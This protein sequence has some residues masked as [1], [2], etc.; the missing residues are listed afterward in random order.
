VRRPNASLAALLAASLLA[1]GCG[2]CGTPAPSLPAER[3][4]PGGATGLVLIPRLAAAAGQAAALHATLSAL[5]GQ[6]E[7]QALRGAL[8]AQLSF[9][10]FDPASMAGA[11]LDPARGAALAELPGAPGEQAGRLLLVLPVGDAGKL[12]ALLSRLARDRLGAVERGLENANGKP[13]E[14]WRRAAGEPAQLALAVLERTAL[15]GVGPSGPDAL[16]TA[17]ALDPALSL[18]RS[19]AWLRNRAALAEDAAVIL[20]LAPGS[21]PLSS[22]LPGEG[23]AAGLSATARSLRLVV[24]APLGAL[25]ARLRPLAGTGAGRTGATPLDPATLVALRVSASPAALRGLVEGELS[26]GTLPAPLLQVVSALEPPI[27]AGLALAPGADLGAALSSRGEIEPLRVAR[28]EA[29]ARVQAGVDLAPL[30]E[31]L[32]RAAGATGAAGGPAGAERRWRLQAGRAEVAWALAGERLLLSAGP[33][34]GLDALLARG[35]VG[36]D[37]WRPP[38]PAAAE[39]LSGGLG[40]LVLDGPGLARAVLALPPS[41]FGGGPDAVV[42]RSLVE[43]VVQPGG[44]AL[45]ASLRA[46]LPAGALRLVLEVALA[47]PG[48]AP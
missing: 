25:E 15:V 7:L 44:Q 11:G 43:K 36:G 6:Y 32:A 5:P 47:G 10:A 23:L 14:V 20:Y 42:T 27:D 19:P 12:T 2:R 46:D 31:D 1:A 34:G 33:P 41:A 26:G 8:S 37:A 3:F 48:Q 38:N 39:A 45:T 21:S 40:G 13:I 16:R 9:D 18:E 24:A 4:V 22:R 29:V 35:A 17:L 28:A 30:L